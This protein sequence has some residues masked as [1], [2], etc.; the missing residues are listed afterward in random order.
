VFVALV[1]GRT[2][3]EMKSLYTAVISFKVR[4]L[5]CITCLW[6]V[7]SFKVRTL[8]CITCL[9]HLLKMIVGTYLSR[10]KAVVAYG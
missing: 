3:Q 9:L 7:I 1:N 10:I 2:D 5:V 6:A 4:T 8:V